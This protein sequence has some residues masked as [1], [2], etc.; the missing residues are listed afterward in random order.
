MICALITIISSALRVSK[1]KSQCK[2]LTKRLHKMSKAIDEYYLGDFV[3]LTSEQ[4]KSLIGNNNK[5]QYLKQILFNNRNVLTKDRKDCIFMIDCNAV[6]FLFPD[7][8]ASHIK[9][10][11][12]NGGNNDVL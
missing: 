8:Y 11:N 4:Y 12:A 6:K 9:I 7:E 5:L 3:D 10:L 1:Y 2:S